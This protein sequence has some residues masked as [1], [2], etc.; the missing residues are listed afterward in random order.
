VLEKTK[1]QH[2]FSSWKLDSIQ[3]WSCFD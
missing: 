3:C 2:T 1:L